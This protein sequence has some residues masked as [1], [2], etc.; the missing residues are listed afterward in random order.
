[1]WYE[2]LTPVMWDAWKELSAPIEI[3]EVKIDERGTN[4]VVQH[5][6]V[7]LC[8]HL[9]PEQVYLQRYP[10]LGSA[11]WETVSRKTA[12]FGIPLFI[13]WEEL[14]SAHTAIETYRVERLVSHLT[15]KL[16]SI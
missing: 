12:S 4:L 8:K 13:P 14:I 2:F 16:D 3:P 9:I 6:D 15:D 11:V 10:R 5:A 1:M 7:R